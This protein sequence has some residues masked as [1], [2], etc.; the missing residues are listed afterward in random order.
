MINILLA[1]TGASPQ[2]LTETIY[3][4]HIAGKPI[5]DEI[6]VITTQSTKNMLIEGCF[7]QGHFYSLLKEY[8]LPKIQFSEENIWLI[9]DDKGKPI[10]DAKS[11]DE[12]TYMADFIVRKVFELTDDN[13][14]AIHASIA[15]GRKTMA[16]YLGYAMS[17]L[18]RPQDSLSHVFVNDE[19][20]FVKDFYYPTKDN[21][22]VQGKNGVGELNTSEAEVT[23][24]EIP[25]IRM[26]QSVDPTLISSM[27]GMSF[28]HAVAT[29]NV[30]HNGS[31]KIVLEVNSRS[32]KVSGVEIKLTAKNF[33]F[34]CFLVKQSQSQNKGVMVNN[35]E[36]KFDIDKKLS[37]SFLEEFLN[38]SK[39]PLVFEKTFGVDADD[40]IDCNKNYDNFYSLKKMEKDWIQ[41]N[42]SQ[43]N[44]LIASALPN[45]LSHQIKISS[46]SSNE[47][48]NYYIDAVLNGIEFEVK[49]PS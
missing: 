41:I 38:H 7:E 47:Y 13:N 30:A 26:R 22:I 24:A 16:F 45:D 40:F 43:V 34:Y 44:R 12:Q 27:E 46:K 8:D 28:S 18:A 35:D 31:L 21:N 49:Q 42:T 14:L 11:I 23:L 48:Q 20:E 36:R 15:G 6:F 3:G 25:F 10:H 17:L 33:S 29:I 19:F 32:I 2:V 39:H 37:I 4:L 5:P 1:V 9:E